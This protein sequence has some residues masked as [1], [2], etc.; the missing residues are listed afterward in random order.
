[1]TI[2]VGDDVDIPQ[3]I[4]DLIARGENLVTE[5]KTGR[6][7][8]PENAF[9]TVCAF[10][11]CYGGTLLLGVKDSGEIIGI[12]S[13][14]I[15]AIRQSFVERANNPNL[16]DPPMQLRLEQYEIE[17]KTVLM[18]NVPE[19]ASVHRYK[20]RIF[21]RNES[22]DFD[23]TRNQSAVA[24][25]YA[26]KVNMLYENTILP[27]LTIDDLDRGIIDRC[28]RRTVIA[29]PNHPWGELNDMQLV[30]SVGLYRKDLSMGAEGLTVGAVLLFGTKASLFSLPVQPSIDLLVRKKNIDRY[31]VR[32]TIDMNIIESYDRIMKFVDENLPDPFYTVGTLRM[33]LRSKIFHEAVTNLLAHRDYSSPMMAKFVI[34]RNDVRI[35]NSSIPNRIMIPEVQMISCPKNPGILR[36]LRESCFV[37][38]LGSGI[39]NMFKYGKIYGGA[40]PEFRE[41]DIF[42]TTI[43]IPNFDF[44][45]MRSEFVPDTVKENTV[46][47]G[48]ERSQKEQR[49][50]RRLLNLLRIPNTAEELKSW[51]HESDTGEFYWQHIE[52]ALRQGLVQVGP[53]EGFFQLTEQGRVRYQAFL[54]QD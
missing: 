7:Q 34:G 4:L 19:S 35:Q 28:R 13:E 45:A 50:L 3:D 10:L 24:S 11:N 53:A 41:G 9:E 39:R 21:N 1:M 20:G 47:Y 44:P 38:E 31:D 29:R 15:V 40:D 43:H 48:L 49:N 17:G 52:P 18:M 2:G 26:R 27:E 5:F 23:I 6:F 51:F 46:A 30:K 36:F 32:E 33:S 42:T 16:L 25:M 54:E 12:D 8:F 22:G 14:N 37:D